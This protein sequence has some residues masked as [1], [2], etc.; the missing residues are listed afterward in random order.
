MFKKIKS[1]KSITRRKLEDKQDYITK[2]IIERN[3]K[4]GN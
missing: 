1:L 3:E 2:K 4:R